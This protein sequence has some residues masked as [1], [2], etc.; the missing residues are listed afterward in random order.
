MICAFWDFLQYVTRRGRYRESELKR[1]G[2]FYASADCLDE[3]RLRCSDGDLLFVHA[4]RSP[5]SWAIMYYSQSYWS[6]VAM[7]SARGTVFEAVPGGVDEYPLEKYF[8]GG[9]YLSLVPTHLSE[10]QKTSCIRWWDE[11]RGDRYNY[12]GVVRLW[13]GIITGAHEAYRLRFTFDI[14]CVLA[15]A[16]WYFDFCWVRAV[17]A[18]L[19]F[20]YFGM[21]SLNSLAG[22]GRPWRW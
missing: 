13:L 18:L 11:H 5:V 20:C 15:A 1:K 7:T 12:C 9:H 21:L 22:R 2:A 17:I 10:Q 3:F 6:H 4:L 19:A 14:A 8:R 16:S